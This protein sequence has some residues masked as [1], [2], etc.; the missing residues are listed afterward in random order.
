MLHSPAMKCFLN[1]WMDL[2]AF[3]SLL[4][5]GAINWYLMSIVVNSGF[6]AVDVSLS[7]NCNPELIPCIFNYSVNYVKA[8]TIYLSLLFFV[9]VVRGALQA[10]THIS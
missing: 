2:S 4:F 5:I 1:V 6:K 3:L 7:I 8:R 9:A 10:Y